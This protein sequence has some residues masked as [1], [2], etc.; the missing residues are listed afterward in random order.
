MTCGD[1]RNSAKRKL[2]HC[3]I[4]VPYSAAARLLQC[5]LQTEL[6]A[7]VNNSVRL[8]VLVILTCLSIQCV[9][10][11]GEF[12]L[13]TVDSVQRTP[14][15]TTKKT[16]SSEAAPTGEPHQAVGGPTV[17][18]SCHQPNK[19]A[20]DDNLLPRGG[21]AFLA[22]VDGNLTCRK[23]DEGL[24]LHTQGSSAAPNPAHFLQVANVHKS[25]A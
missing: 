9:T 10:D 12:S 25:L 11:V 16:M 22:E 1:M 19:N 2:S 14:K 13:A 20:N 24:E 15:A 23:I 5:L 3:P 7:D 18:V 17:T 6:H 21:G 8:S 4:S